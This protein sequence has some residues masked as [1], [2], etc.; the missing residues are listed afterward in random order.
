MLFKFSVIITNY[1]YA[2]YISEAIDSVLAQTYKNFEIIIVD[3]GSSD[4]SKEII[5]HYQ[6]RFPNII[7]AIFKGNGGQA[8]A[9]NVGF[10]A[11]SGD[12]IAFLDADDYWYSDKLE[13]ISYYHQYHKG[14]QHNLLIN[15]DKKYTFL[16][17]KVAKQ[18]NGLEKYGFFG[19]IPTSGLSF[20]KNVLEQFFPIPEQKFKICAD[21][22][23]KIL[24]LSYSDIFSLDEPKGFYRI[25]QTNN[26]YL[27]QGVSLE[28]ASTMVD[29]LNDQR[30]R[31]NKELLVR[32][33]E[34]S[35]LSQYI[36][37]DLKLSPSKK[38]VI[39]GMGELAKCMFYQLKNSLNITCFSGSF[40]KDENT[41]FM[42]VPIK[43]VTYLKENSADYDKI[44]I[45]STQMVEI[46]DFLLGQ[47]F[48]EKKLIVPRL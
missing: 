26:W 48:D 17:D 36:L 40:V 43:S 38:Y 14:I 45:A 31:A 7:R 12:I 32:G 13:T 19:T 35:I 15:N 10:T 9:F 21:L 1:N 47:G 23:V 22:C 42:N 28:Y 33:D 5:L 29:V 8:S 41:C 6:E 24:F 46:F 2:Q 25:H 11:S 39:Y 30:R 18:K 37:S 3:D 27:N 34:A 4:N 20:Y 16:E 44:I